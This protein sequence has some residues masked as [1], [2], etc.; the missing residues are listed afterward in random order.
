LSYNPVK[1]K[2]VSSDF[3]TVADGVFSLLYEK[4]VG[5]KIP[6]RQMLPV[7]RLLR[8]IPEVATQLRDTHLGESATSP[9]FHNV[10]TDGRSAWPMLLAFSAI[11]AGATTDRI[12]YRNF[13]LVETDSLTWR[14]RFGFSARVSARPFIYESIDIVSNPSPN[15]VDVRGA[16]AITWRL[17]DVLSSSNNGNADGILTPSLYSSKMLPM[18]ASLARYAVIFYASSLVRYRP[19]M[20]DERTAPGNA[21][22]FDSIARECAIHLLIDSL[23]GLEG[24]LQSF[25]D[26][27]SVRW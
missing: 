1:A 8:N 26:N 22:L 7:V 3:L 19:S 4:R 9:L 23:I 6:N 11:R 15:S 21:F 14:A 24:Q 18:P 13:R 17:K 25:Y 5:R 2:K 10:V 16:Q 12:F 27:G 20:F